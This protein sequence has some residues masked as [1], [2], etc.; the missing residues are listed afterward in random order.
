MDEEI[1]I[2]NSNTRAENIKNFLKSNKKIIIII[3]SLII[4]FLFTFFI[5]KDLKEKDKINLSN[6]YNEALTSFNEG[7]TERAINILNNIILEEDSTYSPL[8][9]YFLIDK[10]LITSKNQIN[11]K[12]NQI[13][14]ELDLED[15]IKF[16]VI[17]K[18]ALYNADTATE[19]ELIEI[20]SPITNSESIWKSHSL[21]LLAEFFMSKNEKQKAEEFY[22][23]ILTLEKSNKKIKTLTEKRIQNEFSKK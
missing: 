16:L 17:Y 21:Y 20:L 12:F 9:L 18:K 7:N 1:S 2:I 13:I 4:V 5:F 23:M 11:K 6:D 8:A 3:L 15:E 22:K 10:K 14:E 19:N